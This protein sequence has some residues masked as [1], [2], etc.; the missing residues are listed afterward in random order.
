MTDHFA[1]L[2]LPRRPWLDP[3]ELKQRFH[4]LTARHHP[5]V[6]GGTPD[7]RFE[8]ITTAYAVLRDPA[9]RLRHLLELEIP[10]ALT[11]TAQV[12]ASLAERF[13]EVATLQR[14]IQVFAAQQSDMTTPVGRALAAPERFTM[15]RDVEKIAASIEVDR[16]RCLEL[17]QA[18]DAIWEQRDAST[19]RATC[20][21]P[22]G[23]GGLREVER[24]LA[25]AAAFARV[26]K[27]PSTT[28]ACVAPRGEFRLLLAHVS[29]RRH[30]SRHD[31]FA[32]RRDGRGFPILLADAHGERLTPSI[33]H[34]P[35]TGEPLVGRARCAMRVLEPAADGRFDQ[36]LHRPA[37]R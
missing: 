14:E 32:H 37:D 35:A 7:R 17:L 19:G 18:E 9:A 2:D 12:P 1:A 30:R 34:F 33:V 5:D 36:A 21:A 31:Q 27:L 23:A 26:L 4:E 22:A 13:M 8:A 16:G 15:R 25:R 11:A 6:A 10:E 20:H 24:R 29:H 28:R 3:E